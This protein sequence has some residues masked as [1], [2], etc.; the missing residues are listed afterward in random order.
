M[1]IANAL[2]KRGIISAGSE[3]FGR[4]LEQF[5]FQEIAAH[6]HYSGLEYPVSY[7]RTASGFEVDF[8]LGDK[9][10][11]LEVRGVSE[12]HAHHLRSINAFQE[13]YKPKKAL[14]VSLDARPRQIKD[15]LILP[16]KIFLHDLWSGLII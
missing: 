14:V 5:I 6:S 2:L 4:A 10:V 16:W 8:I 15:I 12:V 1:G 11:A 7:W 3:I 13:E 9:D